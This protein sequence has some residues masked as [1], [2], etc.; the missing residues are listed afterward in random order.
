VGDPEKSGEAAGEFLEK[1]I[2]T[3]LRYR[4]PFPFAAI[5]FGLAKSP[6]YRVDILRQTAY[7]AA[8]Y[9]FYNLR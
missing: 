1:F 8:Q 4:S 5:L 7:S 3:L 6:A 2:T 9:K